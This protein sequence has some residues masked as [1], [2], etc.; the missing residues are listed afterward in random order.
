MVRLPDPEKT[1]ADEAEQAAMESAVA[2]DNALFGSLGYIV[3]PAMRGSLKTA[4]KFTN[5]GQTIW[6]PG[7]TLNGHRAEV[8]QQV[9][10]GD[11]FFGNWADLL[12]GVWGGLDVLVDPYTLSARMN[13]RIIAMWTTDFAVRHPESFAFE[14]DTP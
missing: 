13:T 11:V 10:S 12:Q 6:E 1:G 14:N 2:V 5:T 9:T 8:T 3:E 7:N 4:E